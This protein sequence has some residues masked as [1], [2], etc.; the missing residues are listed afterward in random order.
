[1]CETLVRHCDICGQP[2]CQVEE[3]K[4]GYVA[5]LECRHTM[6]KDIEQELMLGRMEEPC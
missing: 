2:R 6:N 5:C 3:I 4:D 1:M